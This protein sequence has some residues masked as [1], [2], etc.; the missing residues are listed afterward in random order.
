MRPKLHIVTLLLLSN[1]L[2]SAPVCASDLTHDTPTARWAVDPH[3]IGDP[4]PKVGRSLFDFLVTEERNGKREYAIPY[5]YTALI[6]KLEGK[7]KT[8]VK[9]VLIPL[10][11]SLAR[12]VA[13]PDFFKYPRVVMAVTSEAGA[14]GDTRVLYKDRLYIGF[15]EKSGILEIISYNEAAGR[16]EFQV[17]NDYRPGGTPRVAYADRA[18]CMS[19]HQ[20][21]ALIFSRQSWD[22]T[23]ANPEVARQ[24]LR[25]AK[26]FH[27][28]EVERGVDVPQAID[29][30]TERA[31]L[32]AVTQKLWQ[33]GCGDGAAG[34]KCRAT[35][36]AL[37]LQY[38]L[39]GERAFDTARAQT[40][41]AAPLAAQWR[42]RWPGGLLIPDADIANRNPFLPV[43]AERAAAPP[44]SR[45]VGA[46]GKKQLSD[47]IAH[48][49]IRAPFEP[50]DPRAPLEVWTEPDARVTAQLVRGLAEFIAVADARALDA[51]LARRA[52]LEKVV[53]RR[54]SGE[55]A[56]SARD[57]GNGETRIA[58][59]CR[60]AS[61]NRADGRVVVRGTTFVHGSFDALSLDG[62]D[63]H[64]LE[65]GAATVRRDGAMLTL[66]LDLHDAGLR[67]RNA[68]GDAI[69]EIEVRSV[70]PRGDA[71]ASVT[72]TSRPEFGAVRSAIDALLARNDDA[73]SGKPFRRA[74]ALPALLAQLGAPV[75]RACC[76]DTT[77]MPPLVDDRTLP[78]AVR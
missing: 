57:L 32:F 36:F 28:V 17:V 15:G 35:W 61:G 58:F 60:G 20:N 71:T 22:E 46:K 18:V 37:A 40:D 73:L 44:V 77:G 56:T 76:V 75:E 68:A 45:D 5:P 55:C 7:L 29:D 21:A 43:V 10:G 19:C 52:A 48:T 65:P 4:L 31:N 74:V 8:E 53:P 1:A 49:D 23:N 27:G 39:S 34:A 62:V 16:F 69:N 47:L 26:S 25:E 50:L 59:N 66:T 70:N 2:A 42:T 67:V 9:Q 51:A 13:A 14:G 3:D 63:F 6:Q 33:E 38:R 64:G 11:R 41:F 78:V 72:L 24:L 54:V 12:N 30:A